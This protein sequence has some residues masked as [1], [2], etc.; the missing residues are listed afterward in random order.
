VSEYDPYDY[1]VEGYCPACGSEDLYLSFSRP[2]CFKKGCP[3]SDAAAKILDDP[4]IEHIV[5]FQPG[6]FNVQ[7]PI[8][9]RNDGQLLD[10]EIHDA[11]EDWLSEQ[12]LP[13]LAALEGNTY[14]FSK[15][16]DSWVMEMLP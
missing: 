7:H 5:R 12:N 6:C 14:R 10:C 2:T 8:R 11:V 9:E 4:E 15:R 3:D 1:P 16:D 13:D